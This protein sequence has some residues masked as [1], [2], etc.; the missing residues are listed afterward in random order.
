[1]KPLTKPEAVLRTGAGNTSPIK[2]QGIIRI[3]KWAKNAAPNNRI[4]GSHTNVFFSCCGKF[5]NILFSISLGSI[6]LSN[7]L[8]VVEIKFGEIVVVYINSFAS[9]RAGCVISSSYKRL[10]SSFTSCSE[11][12]PRSHCN[13]LIASRKRCALINQIGLS[14]TKHRAI[15]E[16]IGKAAL[17]AAMVRQ[18]MRE[19]IMNCI[20]I[21]V[22]TQVEPNA[23]KIPRYLGSVISAT[24][25]LF[26]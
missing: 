9:S 14:G 15:I 20:K 8:F 22:M 10:N 12:Q 18:S 1:P 16:R 17:I 24:L 7:P 11:T 23:D 13:D 5:N 26:F 25:N 3:P 6:A 4:R 19:P 2:I 21:P